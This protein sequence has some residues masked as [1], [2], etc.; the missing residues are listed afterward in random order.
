MKNVFRVLSIAALIAVVGFSFIACGN[1]DNG[2]GDTDGS[3]TSPK[4]IEMLSIPDG[5]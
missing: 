1:D 3:T 5:K 2:D 4:A